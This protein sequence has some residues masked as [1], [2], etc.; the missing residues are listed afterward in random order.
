MI[1][2]AALAGLAAVWFTAATIAAL[3]FGAVVRRADQQ[4]SH[5]PNPPIVG[6]NG[7]IKEST[8]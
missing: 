1:I 6:I 2:L 5:C 4:Q 8:R 7:R 3:I